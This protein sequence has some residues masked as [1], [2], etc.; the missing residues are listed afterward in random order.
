M[1]NTSENS[2]ELD[3]ESSAVEIAKKLL[4]FKSLTTDERKFAA[5][6]LGSFFQVK[7]ERDVAIRQLKEIW[8]SLGQKMDDILET[9]TTQ[10]EKV[11]EKQNVK[12]NTRYCYR[13]GTTFSPNRHNLRSGILCGLI[14]NARKYP[15]D[16]NDEGFNEYLNDTGWEAWMYEFVEYPGEYKLTPADDNVINEILLYAWNEAHPLPISSRKENICKAE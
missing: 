8:K 9:E 15:D 12:D 1:S 14:S 16:E 7:W 10:K 5:M 2:T 11:P 13:T 6:L 4:E 3:I